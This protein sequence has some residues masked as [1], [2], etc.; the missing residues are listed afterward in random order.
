MTTSSGATPVLVSGDAEGSL[1]EAPAL[2]RVSCPAASEPA[3]STL[4]NTK[5]RPRCMRSILP[6]DKCNIAIV[7]S[8][9][10]RSPQKNSHHPQM[11]NEGILDVSFQRHKTRTQST[12]KCIGSSLEIER[13]KSSG[14]RKN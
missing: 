1:L 10:Q 3:K 13:G 9:R 11:P 7:R 5:T 12:R 14:A 2:D 4:I 6:K 8:K